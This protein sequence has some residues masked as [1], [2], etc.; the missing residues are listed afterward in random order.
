MSLTQHPEQYDV[1]YDGHSIAFP[2][3]IREHDHG[4]SHITALLLVQAKC[5]HRD[6]Q[7]QREIGGHMPNK[8]DYWAV[9]NVDN[10]Q[11]QTE[12]AT[13]KVSVKFAGQISAIHG[14]NGSD[15]DVVDATMP[16]VLLN[17]RGPEESTKNKWT[18]R[19]ITMT[20]RMFTEQARGSNLSYQVIKLFLQCKVSN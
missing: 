15:S 17:E 14:Y 1:V 12:E 16:S 6:Q 11:R 13:I 10:L 20:I 19:G 8:L 4:V 18:K 9:E 2:D 7:Q 3:V 5:G